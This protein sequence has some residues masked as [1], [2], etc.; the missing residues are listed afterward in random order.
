MKRELLGSY[1]CIAPANEEHRVILHPVAARAAMV[2]VIKED[3]TVGEVDWSGAKLS[4]DAMEAY[5][6]MKQGTT[7]LCLV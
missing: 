3:V 1:R 2:D 5:V 7:S 6:V 4:S